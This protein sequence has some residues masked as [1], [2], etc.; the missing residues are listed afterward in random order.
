MASRR[1]GLEALGQIREIPIGL[2]LETQIDIG[3]KPQLEP[4]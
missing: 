2:S 1:P 4:D 3:S